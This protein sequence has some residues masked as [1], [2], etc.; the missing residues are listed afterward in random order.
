MAETDRVDSALLSVSDKTGLLPFARRLADLKVRL[1]STGGT[2]RHLREHGVQVEEVSELTG[3]P[4]ILEGRVK[5]LHP[6]I[7]GGILARRSSRADMRTL[8]QHGIGPI[9]L[10]AVNLYPFRETVARG[11]VAPEEA[12]EQID[13]GGPALLRAAAKN[14][15][16]VTVV[17]DPA[18]YPRIEAELISLHR[19]TRPETRLELA[20]KAFRHTAEYDLAVT[21]WLEALAG[22]SDGLPPAISLDLRLAAAVR[23]GENPHQRG[24]LYRSSVQEG[25]VA[26][27]RQ[28]QGKELSFNN[29]LDLDSAW[30]LALEFDQPFCAIVKHTN[31]CGAAVGDTSAEAF[32]RARACDPV[33]AFGSI[34]A[35][36]RRLDEAAAR[37][38]RELFVEAVIAPGYEAAALE[39]LTAKKNLRVMEMDLELE[40]GGELDVRSI[41]GGFLVQD[42]DRYYLEQEGLKVASRRQPSSREWEDLLFAWKVCKHVKSNA[43]VLAHRQQTVG[44]GAGQMSRVDSVRLAA[45]KAVLPLDGSVLASDAFFPFRDGVDGAAD[46]GVE[47]VI[48][49]GGSVRDAEVIEAADEQGVAMVLTGVRH[50]KH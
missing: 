5:S 15:P 46:A 45:R 41:S 28:H 8:E 20:R 7:H 23:Y 43:I 26:A 21:A 42:R 44:I 19:R 2:A 6:R 37:Q 34:V 30:R 4:E 17:V 11:R 48:Q 1:I 12:L 25:G 16:S 49:P 22:P 27:A 33:S 32:E 18:D 3:F 36:N 38:L 31:P 14:H 10:V 29:L 40:G 47:A 35:F 9:S 24:G 50:F 13:I 39:A